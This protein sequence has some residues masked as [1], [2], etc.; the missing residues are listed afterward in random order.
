MQ[1]KITLGSLFDGSGGFPLAGIMCGITPVWASEIDPFCVSVTSKRFPQM[2]HLGDI[3]KI[4]GAKIPPVDIITFGS[5]CQDLSIAGKR[6]GLG[7]ERS[8]LFMEAVRIIKEMRGKTNGKYPKYI[9]WENV[10]GAFSSNKGE[11]FRTVLEEIAKIKDGGVSVPR[12]K[13][14][15]WQTAG[16]I[17]GNGYSLAWR[18]LDAQFWGVPQRRKRIF[19]VGSFGNERAGEILFKRESLSG[20]FAESRTAWKRLA[21]DAERNTDTSIGEFTPKTV[22]IRCGCE[23]GGKGALVQENKS[24]TLSCNNDQI[25]FAA[26]FKGKAGSKA[27]SIGYSEELSP[28]LQA[29]QEAHCMCDTVLFDRSQI[30]SKTNHSNPQVNKP[31]HT[32]AATGGSPVLCASFYPQMKAESQCYR[33]NIAN[34]LVNGTNAGF[35]N[36]VLTPQIVLNDQGGNSLS[37]ENGIVPTL[38]AETHGNEPCVIQYEVMCIDQGGGK[39]QCGISRN[40]SPTIT[41]THGGKPCVIYDGRGNGNGKIAP[42]ICGDHNDRPGDFSAICIA[43]NTINRK[44]GNG[45]NGKGIIKECS[46]TLNTVDKH[47]VAFAQDAY[48]KYTEKNQCSTLRARNGGMDALIYSSPTD[49][50]HAV[51]FTQDAYDKY[52]ENDRT[53]SLRAS[54]GN[55]GGGSEALVYTQQELYENHAQDSRYNGPLEVAPTVAAA[56]GMG[57]NTT[58]FVT[59]NNLNTYIVRRLTPTE[60]AL[61][62]GFP[63]WWCSDIPHK[64]TPEYRMWGN[65][66]ALPCVLYVMEG[67]AEALMQEGKYESNPD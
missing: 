29:E 21:A 30:T 52:T 11:D 13:N 41:C 40:F 45:G 50:K 34:T 2:R 25:L 61:L 28:T 12:P 8:G 53:N 63:S 48:D 23:G 7:G 17:V 66:V 38:R 32:L 33:E 16:C 49:D 57:G 26:G 51:A 55:Y 65:G 3:T 43:G 27:G 42:T 31:C 47:A 18:V 10:P 35:Q 14:G 6:A 67:I 20:N 36:A 58:P 59:G 5:P 9:V 54:G 15:K 1:E 4:D 39:S 24:A 22:K 64:D 60:C 37:V 19:L 56:Y 62:Q 46:Y 44:P